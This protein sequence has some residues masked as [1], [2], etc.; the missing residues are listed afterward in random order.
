MSASH[1]RQA[2]I[3]S[4]AETSFP[5]IPASQDG[6]AKQ[7][8]PLFV[9]KG[10]TGRPA[11]PARVA[12][13]PC[14]GLHSRNAQHRALPHPV[15]EL[16]RRAFITMHWV[17]L[18]ADDAAFHHSNPVKERAPEAGVERL[19]PPARAS[20]FIQVEASALFSSAVFAGTRPCTSRTQP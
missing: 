6:Y 18:I 14:G 12:V 16:S 19:P 13:R 17:V 8:V 11:A 2:L 20:G 3:I 4:V 7:G 10:R 15:S 5:R 9:T 1:G